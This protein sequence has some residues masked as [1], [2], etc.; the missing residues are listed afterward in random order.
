MKLKNV[1]VLKSENRTILK[2][3]NKKTGI[4]CY[5]VIPHSK[6]KK[7]FLLVDSWGRQMLYNENGGYYKQLSQKTTGTFAS[8][9]K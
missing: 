4:Y 1:I 3:L 7:P 6:S 5:V 9:N 2:R 8:W